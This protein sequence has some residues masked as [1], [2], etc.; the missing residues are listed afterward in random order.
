MLMFNGMDSRAGQPI[1]DDGIMELS[2]LMTRR[3]FESLVERS[4]ADGISVAQFLRR[5]VQA[6]IADPVPTHG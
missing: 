5:L 1:D 4:R 6:S 3:Q 2:L